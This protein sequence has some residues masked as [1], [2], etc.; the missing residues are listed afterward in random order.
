MHQRF[1]ADDLTFKQKVKTDLL[2][3]VS[4]LKREKFRL[5]SVIRIQAW[6]RM[7]MTRK[8]GRKLLK[9]GCTYILFMM[10]SD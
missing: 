4:E 1:E 8:T 9:V 2:K 6:W 10:Y 7:I 5:A 3:H